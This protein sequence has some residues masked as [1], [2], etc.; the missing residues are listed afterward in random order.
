MKGREDFSYQILG[1]DYGGEEAGP[2]ICSLSL[3]FESF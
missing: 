3:Y 1:E 2:Q